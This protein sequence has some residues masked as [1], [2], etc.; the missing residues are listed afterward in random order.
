ML[1]SNPVARR[2][3]EARRGV[4]IATWIGEGDSRLQIRSIGKDV[5]MLSVVSGQWSRIE[6]LSTHEEDIG[7]WA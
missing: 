3:H 1:M 2:L 5:Q 7:T 4:L 6:K